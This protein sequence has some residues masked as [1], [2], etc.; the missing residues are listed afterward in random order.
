MCGLPGAGKTTQA[1]ALATDLGAVRLAPDEWLDALG[2]DLWD[3][4]M[5]TRLERT[6]WQLGQELLGHGLSV[7]LDFGLGERADR[8]EKRTAARAI[9]VAVELRYLVMPLDDLAQ[10]L[11]HRSATEAG[12]V[13]IT[14][15]DLEGF[16]TLFE[17]PD[18]TEMALFDGPVGSG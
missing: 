1:R 3:E 14:R 6:L 8:D 5:R 16:A 11:G 10:R 2:I 4:E 17:P 9:G 15:A 12:G 7:I 18:A 13:I